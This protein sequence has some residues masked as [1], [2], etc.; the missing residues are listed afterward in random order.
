MSD[1]MVEPPRRT[2]PT[3]VRE[4]QEEHEVRTA[5]PAGVVAAAA[6][7]EL[8]VEATAPGRDR[9]RFGP[10]VAGLLTALTTLLLLSLLGLVLGLGGVSPGYAGAT[11]G[12]PPEAGP[13]AVFWAVL[14]AFVA[15]LL[16]GYVAGRTAAVYDVR[17]G[18]LNG[19]LVFMLAVPVA[20]WLAAQ[21]AGAAIGALG[22]AANVLGVDPA[23][24]V[25]E[26]QTASAADVARA[27]QA[28]QTGALGALLGALLGL[29]AGALGGA[30]GTRALLAARPTVTVQTSV[31]TPAAPPT[32]GVQPAP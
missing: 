18:T 19:A 23:R 13:L 22:G 30:L 8:E 17:W 21:G 5:P 10:V 2:E 3:E 26:A 27:A 31:R 32:G 20:L 24:L 7:P 15:F 4:V 25:A 12:P 6:P 28:G 1:S 29:V 11:A 9:V 16:G 14:S